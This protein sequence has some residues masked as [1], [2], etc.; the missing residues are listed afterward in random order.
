M[1]QGAWWVSLVLGIASF[2]T[3]ACRSEVSPSPSRVGFERANERPPLTVTPCELTLAVELSAAERWKGAYQPLEEARREV[4]ELARGEDGGGADVALRD[5][6]VCEVRAGDAS[7]RAVVFHGD[8]LAA[9]VERLAT[10]RPGVSVERD[11]S[12]TLLRTPARAY[13]FRGSEV[14]VAHDVGTLRRV[15]AVAPDAW[16][17]RADA[18]VALR[19]VGP[20]ARGVFGALGVTGEADVGSL[21]ALTLLVLGDGQHLQIRFDARTTVAAQAFGRRLRASLDTWQKGRQTPLL[22]QNMAID[23]PENGT[24]VVLSPGVSP[25]D[26]F[27]SLG[28]SNQKSMTR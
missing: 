20:R 2:A 3:P 25:D 27:R 18:I 6:T 11:G 5:A 13:G 9:L 17:R 8:H 22:A 28:Y 16:K 10:P 12:A 21:E 1:R 23:V 26:F 19:V 7:T 14:V 24:S 15:L 4:A